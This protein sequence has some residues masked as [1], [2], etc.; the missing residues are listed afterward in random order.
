[1]IILFRLQSPAVEGNRGVAWYFQSALTVRPL[2]ACQFRFESRPSFE[3]SRALLPRLQLSVP[4]IKTDSV[5][6]AE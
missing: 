1:M 6:Y 2:F 5:Q 3:S 4:H